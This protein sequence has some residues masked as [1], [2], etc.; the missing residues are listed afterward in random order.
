V[1]W[2]TSTDL[3][4][5]A[6]TLDS[7][8]ELPELVRDLIRASVIDIRAF[9]FPSGDSAQIPGWDGRL[10]S[11]GALPYVPEGNSVWEFG[12]G[13]DY[14][15]K[16][17]KDYRTRS[18]NPL[19]V[20][21]ISTTFTFITPRLWAHKKVTIGKWINERVAEGAWKDVRVIDGAMLEDWLE[22][23]PAVASR[24]ARELLAVMPASGVRSTDEFWE[25]YA[26]RFSPRLT[27]K[28][29]LADRQDQANQL[30]NQLAGTSGVY[31][32][33]ADSTEEV[34]AF[35]VAAIRSADVDVRR[36]FEDRTLIVD[37][38]EAARQLAHRTRM[39]VLPRSEARNQDGNLGQ[40][41]STVVSIGRDSPN[42]AGA[43][44]L[45]RP[46]ANA[47]AEALTTMGLPPER[48]SQLARH[49]GRSVT[50]LA[51]RIPS[52]SAKSPE[53]AGERKLIAAFL[54]GAWDARSERDREAVRLAAGVD[55]YKTYSEY[56]NDLLP[57]LKIQD[58][59]FER[60]GDVWKVRAPVDALAYVGHLVGERDLDRLAEAVQT[61][62]RD[63]D[64][65]LDLPD[66]QRP[67]ALLSGKRLEHSSYLRT[68]LATTL[69]LI[70]VLHVDLG[71]TNTNH[72]PDQFVEKMIGDLPGL[73]TDYRTVASLHGELTLLME[74]APRPLL[75]ALG[76][77]LEGEGAAI[78]PIFQD[79][80]PVF[81]QSPHTGL[82]WALESIAWDPKYIADATLTLAKLARIDPGGTLMNRPLNSLRDI[83]LSWHPNTNAPFVQRIAALDQILKYEPEVGWKLVVK[84]LPGYHEVVSPT[85]K[86]RYREA[87]ASEAEIVT[88]GLV[89][90][91]YDQVIERA[92]RLAN[93]D[94]ERWATLITQLSMILNADLCWS[95]WWL[96]PRS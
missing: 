77:M 50:I 55:L 8:T 83:L 62:F 79:K 73:A 51:R 90:K 40:R 46:T 16:A 2:I 20:D 1:K 15:R 10:N 89:Y 52:G 37:T 32:W 26:S 53:W 96:S 35:A 87:G 4:R 45:R 21:P 70:S 68:G 18:N 24:I 13:T 63:I 12:T 31:L 56:E 7:E 57:F 86:P 11:L 22:Q 23:C 94:V 41:S 58:P 49:C 38:E 64:P 34:V 92:F 54:M 84:L 88:D 66:E 29:L 65:A 82:L 44:V 27:E 95:P 39:V 30:L 91:A 72:I 85:V 17:N 42:R 19:G 47:L 6:N 93:Q 69:L 78:C 36:F 59:P 80:D 33:Q 5:W 14:L 71:L 61:V 60:V 28:V 67:Y 25:E 43:A 75:A 81:S 3:E 74:A 76:R 48:A 9:R